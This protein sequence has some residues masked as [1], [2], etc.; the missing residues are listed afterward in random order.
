M[1]AGCHISESKRTF[2]SFHLEHKVFPTFCI[3]MQLLRLTKDFD[4][5]LPY[6]EIDSVPDSLCQC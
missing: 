4:V 3:T 6:P 5:E 2:L 1:R